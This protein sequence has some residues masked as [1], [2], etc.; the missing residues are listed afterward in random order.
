MNTKISYL[1][2]LAVVTLYPLAI[3]AEII[4]PYY[5]TYV[6]SQ[7]NYPKEIFKSFTIIE[8]PR[9][10]LRKIQLQ[11]KQDI[12]DITSDHSVVK[13][14]ST[15]EFTKSITDV[16]LLINIMTERY[17]KDLPTRWVIFH[18]GDK[19]V[20]GICGFYDYVPMYARAELGYALSRAYWGKGL[21]TEAA[22]AVVDFGFKNM[23]LNRIEATC[24]PE[25]RA[26]SHILEKVGMKYEGILRQHI[27]KDGKYCDR[28]MY[29]ILRSDWA[30]QRVYD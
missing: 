7:Q 20:I 18:K 24:D 14:T 3:M 8:T 28:K 25:N 21:G 1:I 9:L 4:V 10:I 16:E 19:K 6:I 29:A 13:Y 2:T 22:Q 17:D 23:N 12:F 30:E 15:L 27:F 11:D 5:D 26:S